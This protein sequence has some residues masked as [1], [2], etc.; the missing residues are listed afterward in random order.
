MRGLLLLN[1][2]GKTDVLASVERV[3]RD[4]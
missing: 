3:L 1:V 2:A 4:A